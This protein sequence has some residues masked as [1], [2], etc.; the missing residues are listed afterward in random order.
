[1]MTHDETTD[2]QDNQEVVK[3]WWIPLFSYR[4]K[5]LKSALQDSVLI[6]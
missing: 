6:L 5:Y 4:Y 2:K 3:F 1:M